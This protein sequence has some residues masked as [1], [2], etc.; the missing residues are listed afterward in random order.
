MGK[1]ATVRRPRCRQGARNH[2]EQV[3]E[4]PPIGITE[5]RARH[6]RG[7]RKRQGKKSLVTLGTCE[8]NTAEGA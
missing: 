1:M 4:L 5:E 2:L 3:L 7:T 6:G 8:R